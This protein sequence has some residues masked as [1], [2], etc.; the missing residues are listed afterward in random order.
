MKIKGLILILVFLFISTNIMAQDK[1]K[2]LF[3][4]KTQKDKIENVDSIKLVA[5]SLHRELLRRDSVAQINTRLIDSIRDNAKRDSLRLTVAANQQRDS[6]IKVIRS[7]E[8]EIT[9]LQSN[10]G[11]VDTCMVKL[12]NRWL[13]E[14]FNKKDVEDAISYFDRMY[15]TRFKDSM[16]LVQELLRNYERSYREFQNIIK[17]AQ[18]DPD[19]EIPFVSN[20]YKARYKKEIQNMTYYLRYYNGELNINYLNEQIKNALE[21][22]E[23]HSD[24]K[25][26]DFSSLIDPNF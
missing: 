11:F 16:S 8:R 18:S 6:L 19:R 3:K 7:K 21:I 2:T 23:K 17:R 22:L 24:S 20:D 13:Y 25:P 26:A 4:G 9:T 1:Q 15:S 5:D 14:P 10:A 12:A